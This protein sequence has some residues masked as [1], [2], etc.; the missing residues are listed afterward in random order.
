MTHRRL[1]SA[2]EVAADEVRDL[3]DSGTLQ[4]GQRINPDD[5]AQRLLI[6]RTPI[7]DALQALKTEGLVDIVPRVG[8][9]VRRIS[10]QEAQ[11]VYAIKAALEPLA[12]AWAA[13][14]G[15]DEEKREL[16]LLLQDFRAAADRDDVRACT[17]HVDLLHRKI[18]EM[19][20]SDAF[21]D[22]YRVISGRVKLLRY[23]NMAQP[24]R[25]EISA[26]QHREI[27]DAIT[28]GN[29]TRA[30]KLMRQHMMDAG[31][32]VRRVIATPR[33]PDT[34]RPDVSEEQVG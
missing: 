29:A 33:I 1:M 6:S 34:G 12:S 28:S 13:T 2:A 27:V 31:E 26:R 14:R 21:L 16:T 5:L 18:F 25:L 24:G 32:S 3:I 22:A 15:T 20:R 23:L 4:P 8:A 9:F 30:G 19:A 10:E 17:G 11:D 7:R